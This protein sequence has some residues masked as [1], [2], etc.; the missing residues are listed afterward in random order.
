M[1]SI[2]KKVTMSLKKITDIT[3][4]Q[5]IPKLME[6]THLALFLAKINP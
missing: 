3:Y 5:N 4:I 6:N 2:E 1:L